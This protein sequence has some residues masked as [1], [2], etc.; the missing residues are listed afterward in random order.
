MRADISEQGC[1]FFAMK[2]KT[3]VGQTLDKL[4]QHIDA[5]EAVLDGGLAGRACVSQQL[6]YPAEDT[7]RNPSSRDEP[8]WHLTMNSP[9]HG[10]CAAEGCDGTDAPPTALMWQNGCV[11]H[12]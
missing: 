6:C 8:A 10:P 1:G 5:H 7:D 9:V 11:E 12:P 3:I 4:C 2:H